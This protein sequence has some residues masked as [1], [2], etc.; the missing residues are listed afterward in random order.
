MIEK[1]RR[2]L[3]IKY[4]LVIA[5]ILSLGFAA[6]YAAYRHNGVKLLYDGLYDYL[7]EEVW[8]AGE[9]CNKFDGEPE[10]HKIKS[11]INSLHNFTY[12]V[13]NKKIVHAER[14]EDE[15]VAAQLEHRLLTK[16]FETGKL[17]HENMKSNKQ[18]WYFI[19]VK[20]PLPAD[21]VQNGEVFVLANYT[22]V[23]KN[24][25]AY[26]KIAVSA[27]GIMIVISYLLG[28]FFAARS[29]TYIERSYEKQKKFVSDAAHELRTPLAILCSYIELLEYNPK[30]KN[31]IADIKSEIQQMNEL[32]DKL[33]SIAGYD[34]LTI[35]L[36]KEFLS[37]ND[38]ISDAVRS[39][40]Q[41]CPEAVFNFA[42]T[43]V[44][45]KLKADKVM[46]RQLFNIL[47]DNAV[48]YTNDDKKIDIKLYKQVSN[49]KIVVKDNGI[50]I[51]KE[52][53]PYVFDR[54]WRAE[55]S[56]HQKSLGLGL[57]IAEAVVKLHHGFISVDSRVGEGTTFEIV[58]PLV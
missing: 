36:Q 24:A 10:I 26:I 20:Q 34:N 27:V 47:L 37:L 22:P 1:I 44:K 4:T 8:E 38:M 51:K 19:V 48:K 21:K 25:K 58:L 56:R 23:R 11:D 40:R 18:K 43:D 42:D 49:V 39:M 52:D 45:V 7:A 3:I 35:V 5:A 6:S 41:L 53:L 13:V 54:F 9:F 30:K 29:M 31:M 46:L 17:Y 55:K 33:L 12:W 14:P 57:S 32:V 50:G 16:R 15:A 28:S 2:T